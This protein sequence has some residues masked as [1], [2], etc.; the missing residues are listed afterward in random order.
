M[1]IQSGVYRDLPSWSDSFNDGEIELIKQF[2]STFES[3]INMDV[4]DRNTVDI[5]QSIYRGNDE[6]RM[7]VKKTEEGYYVITHYNNQYL[8]SY[9]LDDLSELYQ[10]PNS[11]SSR[12][13]FFV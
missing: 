2:V 12:M 7:I 8:D 5:T 1:P 13:R 3:P 11:L 10:L 4:S 6:R 9:K